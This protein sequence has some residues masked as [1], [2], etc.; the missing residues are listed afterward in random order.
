M[1]DAASK[2]PSIALIL[3]PLLNLPPIGPNGP[4]VVHHVP[5]RWASARPCAAVATLSLAPG[6]R[7]VTLRVEDPDGAE[8]FGATLRRL[9][10]AAG[11]TGVAADAELRVLELVR[12]TAGTARSPLRREVDLHGAAGCPFLPPSNH[13]RLSTADVASIRAD[14]IVGLPLFPEAATAPQF[15]APAVQARDGQASYF[16]RRLKDELSAAV[17]A[18][19]TVAACRHVELATMYARK[20]Q[21][22]GAA[23]A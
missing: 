13:R 22:R 8:W 14:A 21:E 4:R 12:R 3:S 17:A 1:A 5:L 6:G 9:G 18:P 20:I 15:V 19:L 23:A 16:H 10:V 11:E 2:Q 7:M